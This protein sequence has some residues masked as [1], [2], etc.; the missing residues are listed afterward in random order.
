M[1]KGNGWDVG[2]SSGKRRTRAENGKVNW[3]SANTCTHTHTHTHARTY[4][5]LALGILSTA[6][7]YFAEKPET[8][9]VQLSLV[10]T[11]MRNDVLPRSH[12]SVLG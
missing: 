3:M 1:D 11:V 2:M 4:T 6:L 9:T 5:Q 10:A 8:F 12:R 7:P